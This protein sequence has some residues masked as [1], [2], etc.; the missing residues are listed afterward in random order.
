MEIF[1]NPEKDGKQSMTF[2][3]GQAGDYEISVLF[4]G[5]HFQGSP[6]KLKVVD[7]LGCR[8]DYGSIGG[9]PVVRFGSQGGESG[10]FANPNA[11]SCNLRGEIIVTDQSNHRVQVFDKEGKF[12]FKFGSLGNDRGQFSYPYGV[13]VDCQNNNQIIVADTC[14]NRIQVFDEKGGFL[15]SFGSSGTREGQFYNPFGIAVDPVDGNYFVADRDN[16]RIQVFTPK[17]E[18]IR[19]FGSKGSGN[20]QFNY[21]VGMGFLS[22]SSMVVG[23][24]GGQHR[25][26]LFDSTG[27]FV[28]VLGVSNVPYHLFVDSDDNIL[29][30]GYGSGQ[31]QVYDANGNNLKNFGQGQLSG[32]SG[33][34]MDAQGRIIISEHSGHRISI[35]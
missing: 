33:I 18:F 24:Y 8:R 3:L 29:V 26:Q 22:N 14:N 31:I 34:C 10:Q 28:R 13:A 35:F 9:Q 15:W 2:I 20:G 27:A 16:Y 32:P 4:K 21:P 30:A 1:E 19:K 11:V 6:F 12:L 17:G 5:K 25:I 23:E 7:K